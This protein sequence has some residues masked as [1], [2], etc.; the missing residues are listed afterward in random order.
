MPAI[1]AVRAGDHAACDRRRRHHDVEGDR[2]ARRGRRRCG[3]RHGGLHR[4][5]AARALKPAPQA[6]WSAAQRSFRAAPCTSLEC[7]GAAAPFHMSQPA[8]P[9][10]TSRDTPQVGWHPGDPGRRSRR[11]QPG[12]EDVSRNPRSGPT[13]RRAPGAADRQRRAGDCPPPGPASSARRQWSIAAAHI[14]RLVGRSRAGRARLSVRTAQEDL[15]M[16]WLQTWRPS[17]KPP[18]PLPETLVATLTAGEAAAS[19]ARKADLLAHLGW[20]AALRSGPGGEDTNDATA[21]SFFRQAVEADPSNPYAHAHWG[22]WLAWQ[23]KL[24]EASS[25]FAA[26]LASGR[27]RPYVR[28]VQLAALLLHTTPAFGT[29]YIAAVADM[30]R[31]GEAVDAAVRDRV[32][33]LYAFTVRRRGAVCAVG[34]GAAGRGADRARPH[35]FHRRWRSAPRPHRGRVLLAGAPAG[36]GRRP[37]G[38]PRVMAVG[39][40]LSAAGGVGPAGRPGPRR[41][42]GRPP[43]SVTLSDV[44]ITFISVTPRPV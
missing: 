19:G 2:R 22:Y 5:T 21:E 15:A 30:V 26:A 16:A 31:N 29:A 42:C 27:A 35:A 44:L 41:G 23:Q 11:S 24:G 33:A 14:A 13:S 7:S 17:D 32:Y 39:A 38:R 9:T 34:G 36:G 10:R 3:R 40:V 28:A 1:M 12:V 6:P 4:A 37:G 20:E 43:G 18:A 8:E 25:R